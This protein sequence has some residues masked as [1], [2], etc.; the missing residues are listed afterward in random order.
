M[1]YEPCGC[2]GMQFIC[3]RWVY[4]GDCPHRREQRVKAEMDR[5]ERIFKKEE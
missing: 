4:T 3:N 5:R 2:N 1:R